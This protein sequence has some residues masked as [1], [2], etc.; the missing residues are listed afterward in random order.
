MVLIVEYEIATPI[1]RRTV[2]AVSR[3]DIEEIYQSATGE[4]KLIVWMYASDLNGVESALADDETVQSFTLLEE[5]SDRRLYSVSLSDRGEEQLTYP[6]A[7]EYDIAYLDITVTKD[8]RIR[9]RIPTRDALMAYRDHCR[10][11]D[12]PF[13]IHRIFSE[14]DAIG[15][16]YGV[17]EHQREALLAAL[18][19][20]YFDVPRETTLSTIAATLDISDQALSARLRR[21]QA[22]L[23]QNTLRKPDAPDEP[24][25]WDL[26]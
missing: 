20:G 13:R 12:I 24:G 17:T 25:E 4:T 2:E 1:L 9:A 23:L 8:T 6:A 11:R 16:R 19:E 21:G 10:E 14:S 26:S 18:D 15:D 3:I 7:A 5:R 22:N